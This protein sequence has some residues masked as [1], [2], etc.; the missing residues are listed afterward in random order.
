MSGREDALIRRAQGGDVDAFDELLR[1]H[2]PTL[3]A[4]CRALCADYQF[5]EDAVQ[6]TAVVA[7]R[8]LG[9]FFPESDFATW[10][11]AIA[12]RQALAAGRR[13]RRL[14]RVSLG[15][16]EEAYEEPADSGCADLREALI[17]CLERLPERTAAVVRAHYFEGT[18][19]KAIAKHLRLSLSSVKVT[20]FRA[21]EKLRDCTQRRLAEGDTR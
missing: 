1:P 9:R 10:L 6:E 14:G 11:R 13:W 18:A 21:R 20:L 12:R 7:F 15:L 8:N 3:L 5:A 17:G 4:Y 16:L 2:L 19:L